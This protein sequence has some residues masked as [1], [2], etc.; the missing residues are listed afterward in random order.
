MSPDRATRPADDGHD[1]PAGLGRQLNNAVPALLAITA[2]LGDDTQAVI[3]GIIL[4]ISV[5]LRSTTNFVRS[6]PRPPCTTASV[7][8]RW[9][10]AAASSHA[11]MSPSVRGNVIWLQL[12]ELVPADVRLIAVNG[13]ECNESILTGES[14]PSEK[15]AEPAAPDATVTDASSVAFM[16]TVVSAGEATGVVYATGTAAEFGRM[17]LVWVNTNR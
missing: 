16:G 8:A 3:I 5:G 12:G 6:G 17:Q 9:P 1:F 4:L 10:A 11:S 2:V 7:T 15:S 13:L 14:T